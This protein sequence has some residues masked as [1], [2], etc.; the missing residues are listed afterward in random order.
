ML[1]FVLKEND[2]KLPIIYIFTEDIFENINNGFITAS[3]FIDLKK[4][5]DTVNH[6]ILIKKI[7]DMGIKGDILN[8]C[9]NYLS[10]RF[11]STLCNGIKS[12]ENNIVCGVPQGSVLGP[13]FFLIYINDITKI[14]NEKNIQLYADDTVLFVK[15][16]NE[17]E[18]NESLQIILNKFSDWCNQNKLSINPDKTKYMC[19]GTRQRLKKCKNLCFTMNNK[20]ILSVPSY[21]YLGVILDQTLNFKLHVNNTIN[22]VNHK[23]YVLSKLMKYLTSLSAI[24]IYKS[25]ILPY[26]DYGDIL[27]SFTNIPEVSKLQRLQDRCIKICTRTFGKADMDELHMNNNIEKLEKRRILHVRHHM[28]KNDKN[29]SEIDDDTIITRSYD[30]KRFI[31]KKPNVEIYKRSL[32]YA[33]AADWNTLKADL[34]NIDILNVFKFR[35][36][37]EK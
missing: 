14:I 19:F 33:G 11:Q 26:F 7:E 34:R 22:K 21:K 4:A 10:N 5:F 3:I 28:F 32:S 29:I 1:K 31:I 27:Y 30:G 2:K 35:I 25:M 15:G 37:K 12:S 13:L 17:N 23:I 36:R 20:N 9:I 8:W 18:I 24:R 16:K 6:N